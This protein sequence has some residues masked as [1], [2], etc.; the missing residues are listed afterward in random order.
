MLKLLPSGV[1]TDD[2][3]NRSI[4]S[5]HS[6]DLTFG[7]KQLMVL[8][9]GDPEI[10]KLYGDYLANSMKLKDNTEFKI[11]AIKSIARLYGT[12]YTW[13]RYQ[14]EFN[15]LMHGLNLDF[16]TDTVQFI[17]YGKRSYSASTWQSLI[18]INPDYIVGSSSAARWDKLCKEFNIR[19]S[20]DLKHYIGMWCSHTNGFE[21]MLYTTW[22]L[23]G[24]ADGVTKTP[25]SDS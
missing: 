24:S 5:K 13:L 25:L 20:N 8:E 17:M 23:F 19:T 7:T 6:R 22:V 18:E 15:Y 10:N 9:K 4:I 14:F 2:D 21:D 16:L 12:F 3:G 1:I 11:K